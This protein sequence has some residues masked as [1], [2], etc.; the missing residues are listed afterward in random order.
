MRL[1]LTVLRLLMVLTVGRGGLAIG[2]CELADEVAVVI[3]SA[4]R[5]NIGDLGRRSGQ[6]LTGF[7][8]P[9]PDQILHGGHLEEG[10]EAALKLTER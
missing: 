4:L 9:E 1:E 6:R 3:E 5:S 2:T 7:V 8:E 10:L